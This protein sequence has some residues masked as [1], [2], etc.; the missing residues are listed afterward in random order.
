MIESFR[1]WGNRIHEAASAVG[2]SPVSA[3]ALVQLEPDAPISQKELASRL[4]CKP[5][6]VVDPTD[7]LCSP[8]CAFPTT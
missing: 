8:S 3:W 6:T 2:L 5:S 7:R 1:L 4:H